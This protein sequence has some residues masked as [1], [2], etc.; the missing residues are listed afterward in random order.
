VSREVREADQLKK[1]RGVGSARRKR[2]AQQGWQ[3]S[4]PIL[5]RGGGL[6]ARA[7]SGQGHGVKEEGGGVLGRLE[8]GA[9]R[10]GVTGQPWRNL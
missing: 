1:K 4:Y 10:K 6:G 9:E 8:F 7:P 2:M 5:E 3:L